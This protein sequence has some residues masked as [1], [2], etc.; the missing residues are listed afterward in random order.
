M[1][2]SDL[3][4]N[5]IFAKG[6]VE[7]RDVFGKDAPAAAI[8]G[9][10]SRLARVSAIDRRALEDLLGARANAIADDLIGRASPAEVVIFRQCLLEITAIAGDLDK[11]K[12]EHVR[13]EKE[14][15]SQTDG[16]DSIGSGEAASTLTPQGGDVQESSM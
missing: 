9:D 7:P 11:F 14:R 13:R 5:L 3:V 12:A 1:P 10:E 16:N 2:H 6:A 4:T 15:K 8:L